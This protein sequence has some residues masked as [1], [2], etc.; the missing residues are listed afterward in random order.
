MSPAVLIRIRWSIRQSTLFYHSKWTIYHF[1]LSQKGLYIPKIFMQE[2]SWTYGGRDYRKS[3]YSRGVFRT[4]PV[5][6]VGLF[7]K[8]VKSSS[9][10]LFLQ[11][12]SIASDVWQGPKCTSTYLIQFFHSAHNFHDDMSISYGNN[13]SVMT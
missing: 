6:Y 1:M 10:L 7:A 8:I 13:R 9:C 11:N 2:Y 4:L 12:I 5:I 3:Q